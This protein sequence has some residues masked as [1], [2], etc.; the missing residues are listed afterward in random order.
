VEAIYALPAFQEWLAEAVKEPWTVPQD[1]I[2]VLLAERSLANSK[3]A[4]RA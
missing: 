4:G 2:D 1:E 3:V